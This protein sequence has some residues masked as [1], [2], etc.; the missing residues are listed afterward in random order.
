MLAVAGDGATGATG[1]GRRLAVLRPE[2]IRLEPGDGGPAD[3][4]RGY[5]RRVVFLGTVAEYE[6]ESGEA[7]LLVSVANPVA[8]R[9]FSEGEAV[10]IHLPDQP[11]AVVGRE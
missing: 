4:P 11:V 3:R 10:A 6:V 5:V 8:D 1:R 9:L 7:T 2:A